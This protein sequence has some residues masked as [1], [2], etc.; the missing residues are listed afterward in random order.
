MCER[1]SV[2]QDLPKFGMAKFLCILWRMPYSCV[3]KNTPSPPHPPLKMKNWSDH[4]TLS[5]SSQEYPHPKNENLVRS[6]HFEFWVCKNTR[7]PP[8][9]W[10]FGQIL[11][12]ELWVVKNTPPNVWR[13]TAVSPTDTVSFILQLLIRSWYLS[14]I[15]S[16]KRLTFT[17]W[18]RVHEDIHIY[19]CFV[20]HKILIGNMLIFIC[21][22]YL[23]SYSF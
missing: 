14:I 13:L 4:G 2:M 3:I 7:I 12:L 8:P 17:N 23:Y 20:L 5:L 10:K 9:Q 22:V 11:A 16:K 18:T 21:V 6:W 19:Y 15:V 1:L